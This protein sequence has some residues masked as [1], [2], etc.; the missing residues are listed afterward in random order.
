MS[1]SVILLAGGKG[2][3]MKSQLPKQFIELGGK[4]IA[5]HSLEIFL[6]NPTVHEVIVVC[7][8]IYHSYFSSYPVK[9]AKPGKRRQD[10][11]FNGLKIATH[12]WIC[13]HDSVRPFITQKMLKRLFKAGKEGGA[14]TLGVPM[15]W[16]V[17]VCDASKRVEK[18]LNRDHLWEAQTPQLIS[19]GVLKAGFEYAIEHN[20]TATDDVSLVELID[21]PVQMV[22]GAYNNLKIT[23]PEDLAIATLYSEKSLEV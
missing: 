12:K 20:V 18:T 21:H 16:T 11:L 13:I 2:S 23:T 15:K 5:Y 14:A 1:V 10:S 7:D 4:P 3:R 9:F 8:P 17:K 19:K 22:E 6:S